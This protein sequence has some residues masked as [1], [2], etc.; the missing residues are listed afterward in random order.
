MDIS[1]V[2]VKLVEDRAER[3][4]AFCSVTL[5]GDFVIRDLKII[6]GTNGLFVAMPSRKLTDHCHKCRSKNH[7]RAR[8]CNHCGAS[9]DENRAPRDAEGRVK[10]HADIAHPIN[11]AFRARLQEAAIEAFHDEVGR[12]KEPGYE[13]FEEDATDFERTDYDDFVNDLRSQLGGTSRRE[14][15]PLPSRSAPKDESYP[16]RP[17]NEP[18]AVPPELIPAPVARLPHRP[19][20]PHPSHPE[21]PVPAAHHAHEGFAAGLLSI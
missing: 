4:R 16:K 3:V 5:D 19:M 13:P 2:R 9:L 12:S 1:E 6:E 8:F 17:R 10:L 20:P 11:A 21:P 7:L 18:K 14:D 15:R